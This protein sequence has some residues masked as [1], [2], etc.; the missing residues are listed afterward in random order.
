MVEVMTNDIIVYIF[1][2]RLL[3]PLEKR[4]VKELEAWE[5][6]DDMAC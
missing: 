5:T 6:E 1:S 3:V 2:R 4:A